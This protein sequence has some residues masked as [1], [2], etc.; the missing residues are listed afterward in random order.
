MFGSCWIKFELHT[1]V[2]L[3]QQTRGRRS[4]EFPWKCVYDIHTGPKNEKVTRVKETVKLSNEECYRMWLEKAITNFHSICPMT[5]NRLQGS[6]RTRSIQGLSWSWVTV[7]MSQSLITLLTKV[8]STYTSYYGEVAA[9]L[10]FCLLPR[11]Y[12][13][14]C[15]RI[16]HHH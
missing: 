15:L 12:A 2:H 1:T 11:N 3:D 7:L 9:L 16:T 6:R 4:Q 14:L 10:Y 5:I 8:L 13:Q